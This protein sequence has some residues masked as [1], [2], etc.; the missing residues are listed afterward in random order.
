MTN[1]DT[2]NTL[3]RELQPAEKSHKQKSAWS[4]LRISL[5]CALWI[6]SVASSRKSGGWGFDQF[7]KD[8]KP[9]DEAMLKTCFPCYQAI[10]AR[11]FVLPITHLDL[12]TTPEIATCSY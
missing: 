10:K 12:L 11:D 4:P 8:G 1:S 7:N 6:A 3:A 2:K 5:F 9:A